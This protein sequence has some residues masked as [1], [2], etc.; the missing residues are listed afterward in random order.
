MGSSVYICVEPD[1]SD[2]GFYTITYQGQSGAWLPYTE[3]RS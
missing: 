3:A 2:P 1:P